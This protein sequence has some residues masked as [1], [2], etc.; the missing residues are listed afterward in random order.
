[1]G[2]VGSGQ[3]HASMGQVGPGHEI[4][5]HG[6]LCL[7]AQFLPNSQ[8]CTR[9]QV[10]FKI[11]IWSLSGDKQPS[12]KHFPAVGAFALKFSIAPRGETTDRIKKVGGCKDGTDLL[13]HYAKY[14]GDSGSRAGCRRKSVMFFCLSRFRM[15]KFV[16][17][18]TL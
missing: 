5:T 17:T 13:Y 11:L 4:V 15:T 2:R 7:R 3:V 10:A 12:Y 6:Q 18:E 14:G 16:I 1:V 9:L 8:V